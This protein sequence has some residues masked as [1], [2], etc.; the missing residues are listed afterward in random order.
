[1]MGMKK[2]PIFGLI[3]LS[4]GAARAG[5]VSVQPASAPPGGTATVQILADAGVQGVTAA[6]L[7]VGYPADLTIAGDPKSVVTAGPFF[8]DAV[9][10]DPNAGVVEAIDATQPQRLVVVLATASG[11]SGPAA[12]VTVPFRVPSGARV[13][14]R[15]ALTLSGR[16]YDENGSAV[17][18]TVTG[19]SVQVVAPPR[20]LGSRIWVQDVTGV[21]GG[22]VLLEIDADNLALNV[23][24]AHLK[25]TYGTAV[26]LDNPAGV[27]LGSV[28]AD[29]GST[30]A[31]DTGTAGVLG[32]DVTGAP[33]R[34]GPG[35]LALLQAT[36]P[37]GT[38]PGHY[39]L[40]FTSA[41]LTDSSGA[42]VPSHTS[43]GTLTVVSLDAPQVS[44]RDVTGTPGAD[45]PGE[46]DADG[47]VQDMTGA[48]LAAN[49]GGV[50][51]VGPGDVTLGPVIGGADRSAAANRTIAG[52]LGLVLAGTEPRNGPGALVTFPLHID[53]A[54]P[55]GVYPIVLT[56]VRLAAAPGG[57]DIPAQP[58]SGRLTVVAR[59]RGDATG[60][61]RVSIDDAVLALQAAVGLAQLS[62]EQL[63]ALDVNGDGQVTVA[64]ASLVL[65]AAVGLAAL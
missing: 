48:T 61:G 8:P 32:I 14:T 20:P 2:L 21:P 11:H 41:E 57:T 33:G 40:L 19:G 26:Q 16:F 44:V 12:I 46:I 4:A 30:A 58:V 50:G 37:P 42:P 54:T 36:I 31:V 7:A 65:R 6:T 34:S 18:E 43:D 39:P 38:P 10:P 55:P 52:R 27:T 60:D 17:A 64:D 63:S 25:V 5:Q 47:G 49:F 62:A 53:P 1:M 23:A 13:G 35:D 3:V 59:P 9:F 56:Q 51:A 22:P 45:V 15:F 28:L 24:G 29:A